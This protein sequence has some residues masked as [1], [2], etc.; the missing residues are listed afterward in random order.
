MAAV[1]RSTDFRVPARLALTLGAL[2]AAACADLATEPERPADAPAAA[3]RAVS[4][5]VAAAR[6]GCV[7]GTLP[8]GADFEV[9]FPGTWN[10]SIVFY[11]HGYVA[12]DEPIAVPDD[13][14]AGLPVA[15]IARGL[16][17]VYATSSYRDN[18]LVAAD[19]VADLELLAQVLHSAHPTLAQAPSY[20]VGVSEGGLLTALAMQN[21]S[22]PF[23]GGLALCGPVGNFQTQVDYLGDFRLLFDHFFPGVL[24]GAP[25]DPTALVALQGGWESTW[26]PAIKAAIASDLATGGSGVTYLFGVAGAAMDPGDPGQSAADILWY[27]AFGTPDAIEKLGGLPFGNTTR[28]YAGTPNDVLLNLS[29]PRFTR[30]ASAAELAR[31]QTTG[32]VERPTVTLHTTGDQIVQYLQEILYLARANNAGDLDRITPFP[33]NRYGHCQFTAPEALLSLL[34]LAW[35]VNAEQLTVSSD[36]FVSSSEQREF[37]RMARA[38][39]LNPKIRRPR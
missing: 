3:A 4:G 26:E 9:C 5:L 33:V 21:P 2:A 7:Y 12:S 31:Y 10:G 18:G 22:S 35:R 25:F 17:F 29:I 27:N 16:G 32:Q 39:G 34:V 37:L 15:E 13:R 36:L 30:T 24:P 23:D 38:Q 8:P 11:A 19:G 1:H 28:W 6:P 14:I 20:L